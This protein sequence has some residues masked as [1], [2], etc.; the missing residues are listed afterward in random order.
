MTKFADVFGKELKVRRITYPLV[1]P[2]ANGK[3][4]LLNES[5]KKCTSCCLCNSNANCKICCLFQRVAKCK[6]LRQL[7]CPF[8]KCSNYERQKPFRLTLGNVMTTTKDA[9]IMATTTGPTCVQ[10]QLYRQQQSSQFETWQYCIVG[11]DVV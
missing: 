9:L 5:I 8:P 11:R 1:E 10:V 7:R 6:S 2:A 4:Y 3:S